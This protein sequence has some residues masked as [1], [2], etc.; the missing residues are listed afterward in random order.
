MECYERL[1]QAFSSWQEDSPASL[2]QRVETLET[3]VSALTDD[4]D[5]L[6]TAL[7][8]KQDII[9]DLSEIRSG[10][11]AGATAVQPSDLQNAVQELQTDIDTKATVSDIFGYGT[12]LPD[13]ADLNDYATPGRYYGGN[14][15]GS[16]ALN[17]PVANGTF[18]FS[19]EVKA[20]TPSM[21]YQ[22]IRI[23]RLADDPYIYIR[24][25]YTSWGSWYK[26]EGTAIV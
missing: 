11:A 24:R 3:N 12:L 23:C 26:F 21:I 4:V 8:T 20:A 14:S 7:A 2:E 1:N 18:S 13:N 6:E 17:L 25:K 22:Y 15:T 9:S 10:A 16:T 5:D 19:L